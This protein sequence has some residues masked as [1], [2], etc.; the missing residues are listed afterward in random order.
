[1]PVDKSL[2]YQA[3]A[4]RVA[5]LRR[6]HPD[7]RPRQLKVSQQDLASRIGVSRTTIANV[8]NHR[9]QMPLHLLYD[10]CIELGVEAREILPTTEELRELGIAPEESS[11][12]VVDGRDLIS[13]VDKD[14]AARLREVLDE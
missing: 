1:V 12:T 13:E 14:L 10:M 9:Q 7:G 5:Q 6:S 3:I 2:L 8:E 11:R 4:H